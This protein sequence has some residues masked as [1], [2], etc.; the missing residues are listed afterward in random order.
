MLNQ[1]KKRRKPKEKRKELFVRARVTE[2][3]HGLLTE[4]AEHAGLTLSGWMVTTLL[5]AARQE[6]PE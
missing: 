2:E 6:L 4:A 1:K 3:Q 5:R